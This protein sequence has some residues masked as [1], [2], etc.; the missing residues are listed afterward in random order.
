[1]N[2]EHKAYKT[3]RINNRRYLGNKYKLL[4]FITGVVEDECSGIEVVADIFAG[5]GAVSSAFTDKTLITNDLMYSNYICHYAWFGAETYDPQRIVDF[6][7]RYNAKTNCGE[8]YMTRN[9]ADT[10]FSKTDCAKIGYIREDIERNYKKGN[11]NKRERAILIT[12]LLYAMDKIAMTCGHYD[13]YRKGAEFEASLELCVPLAEVNNNPKNVCFNEDANNL[14]KRIDADLVYIDPPYNSRQYCDAY[15]LLEN[16]A[17]W[18]KPQVYGV[19]KKM[20]RTGMKSRYCTTSAAQAFETLVNDIKAK[21]ILL[22]YNNMAEKGNS[23]SNAKISDEDIMCIL[24]KKGTVKV[25]EES[26]KAF[27]AGKSD[28][29]QNAERLFLCTCFDE[30]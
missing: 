18:E 29:E 9:F 7:V 11:L 19:A 15:H 24:S 5:T 26:Y 17:R 13:A 21:Y 14:V 8:N 4:S 25:F 6:V 3:S 28:I 30:V 22:S 27:T 2:N 10:Y 16:V 23:R 20:D 12:S 1:M